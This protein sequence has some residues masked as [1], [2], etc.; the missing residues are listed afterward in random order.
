M[1]YIVKAR[2]NGFEI[3]RAATAL[4]ARIVISA[5]E[6]NDVR[7]DRFEPDTYF[8]EEVSG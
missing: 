5:M 1:E 4:E 2:P 6:T 3:C 7:E 8:I